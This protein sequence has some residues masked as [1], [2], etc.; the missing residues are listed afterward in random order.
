MSD[1]LQDPAV[2]IH[3]RVPSADEYQ[4]KIGFVS[5]AFSRFCLILIVED[6]AG[7]DDNSV[8]CWN[9]LSDGRSSAI[10]E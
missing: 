3:N 7:P 6:I 4:W 8:I 2:E 5:S 10:R 1:L 9:R